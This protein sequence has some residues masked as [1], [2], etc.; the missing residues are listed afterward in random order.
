M[1]EAVI[2]CIV[3]PTRWGRSA[4]GNHWNII[5][6]ASQASPCQKQEDNVILSISI[7]HSSLKTSTKI[8]ESCNK[9]KGRQA[10]HRLWLALG[11]ASIDEKG[12][13][14]VKSQLARF[15]FYLVN[16]WQKRRLSDCVYRNSLV[17]KCI[18]KQF[19]NGR[20]GIVFVYFAWIYSNDIN[21]DENLKWV[22][23]QGGGW[24][25]MDVFFAKNMDWLSQI[26][27][28]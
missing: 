13:L 20:G 16:Y 2:L 19:I 10:W 25:C 7:Y 21:W 27:F 1:I 14:F 9:H 28:I 6:C 18:Q 22:L 5:L 3:S 8:L 12:H 26:N 24:W 11:W 15:T 4:K 17:Q 23:V